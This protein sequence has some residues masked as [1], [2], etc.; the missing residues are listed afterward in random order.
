MSEEK[1]RARVDRV[2]GDYF[3]KGKCEVCGKSCERSKSIAADTYAAMEA[4]AAEWGKKPLT[5]K[6]CEDM[7]LA[8][9]KRPIENTAPL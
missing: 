5:H 7:P 4:K 8:K 2:V 1:P 3:R 9:D 6:R